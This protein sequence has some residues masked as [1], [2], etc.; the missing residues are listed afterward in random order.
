MQ[1][2]TWSDKDVT[3]NPPN[4]RLKF[5]RQYQFIHD[6]CKYIFDLRSFM[7]YIIYY[8]NVLHYFNRSRSTYIGIW[9][10]QSPNQYLV[11]EIFSFTQFHPKISWNFY[12]FVLPNKLRKQQTTQCYTDEWSLESAVTIDTFCSAILLFWQFY[13][14]CRRFADWPTPVCECKYL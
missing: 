2:E 13:Y 12:G 3:I 1:M 14:S 8:T 7:L 6:V 9:V 10:N 4:D 11:H 5:T